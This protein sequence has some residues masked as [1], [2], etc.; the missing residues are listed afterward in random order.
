MSER[1]PS[2]VGKCPACGWHC[3]FLGNGGYVTC[4]ISDCPDPCASSDLIRGTSCTGEERTLKPG[5]DRLIEADSG[6]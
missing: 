1:L 2:V 5:L 6:R 3:L 4:S